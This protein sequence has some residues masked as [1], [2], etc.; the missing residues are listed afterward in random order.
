MLSETSQQYP[1]K[2]EILEL[3]TEMRAKGSSFI[4]NQNID[5]LARRHDGLS[6]LLGKDV[7]NQ[8]AVIA[9]IRHLCYHL[10]CCDT[11]LR[12]HGFPGVY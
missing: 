12:E 10:G 6:S 8:N 9:L 3:A 11:A 4:N 2:E 5:S 1:T 7:L